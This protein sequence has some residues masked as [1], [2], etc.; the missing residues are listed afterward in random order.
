[1]SNFRLWSNVPSSKYWGAQS[2]TSNPSN[3]D[4][5]ELTLSRKRS[6][7][8]G[9][10][11]TSHK[12]SLNYYDYAGEEETDCSETELLAWVSEGEE[13]GVVRVFHPGSSFSELIRCT[14]TTD[15]EKVL[16]KC[17]ADE[18]YVHCG[19]QKSQVLNFDTN[20][21]AIQ[22]Q[23]LADIGHFDAAR[24]QLEGV[25]NDLCHMIKFVAGENSELTCLQC[26]HVCYR[27]GHTVL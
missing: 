17:V 22:N 24:I 20:P 2:L 25:Q 14:K 4:I 8:K 19:N 3:E 15:V 1:M 9:L 5:A 6:P 13:R 10:P 21:L 23:Y 7:S 16:S 11:N 12:V 18:L 27:S 26:I